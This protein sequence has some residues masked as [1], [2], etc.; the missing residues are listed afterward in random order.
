[1]SLINRA[2]LWTAEE[3]AILRKHYE[4]TGY[5]NVAIATG[6]SR[7]AITSR[8]RY[9]GLSF[10]GKLRCTTTATKSSADGTEAA[11]RTRGTDGFL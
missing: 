11:G 3:D 7:Y 8:A 2:G 9:L 6:R 4:R 1:M 10:K 5:Y